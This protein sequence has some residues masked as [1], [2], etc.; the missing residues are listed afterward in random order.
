LAGLVTLRLTLA[1]QRNQLLP[2]AY[3]VIEGRWST[4]H[5]LPGLLAGVFS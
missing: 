3:V 5:R 4:F 2:T 1:Y